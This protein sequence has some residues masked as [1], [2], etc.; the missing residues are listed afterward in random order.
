MIADGGAVQGHLEEEVRLDVVHGYMLNIHGGKGSKPASWQCMNQ[1]MTSFTWGDFW[2]VPANA[3]LAGQEVIN[4]TSCDKWVYWGDSEQYAIWIAADATPMRTGKIFTA[5]PGYH[6]WHLEFSGFKRYDGPSGVPLSYFALPDGVSCSDAP[7]PVPP[8][9]WTN[10][11]D[12]NGSC[13]NGSRCCSDPGALG[14]GTGACYNVAACSDIHDS[15]DQDQQHLVASLTDLL[16]RSNDAVFR[17][18]AR[19][20]R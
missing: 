2:D 14:K 10:S 5:V 12:C 7:P 4:G 9:P 3:T 8:T 1:S 6:L 16:Q 15:L 11:S 13:S 20:G 18:V 17:R 19:S